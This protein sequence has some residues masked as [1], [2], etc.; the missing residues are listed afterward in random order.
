MTARRAC[1]ACGSRKYSPFA[2]KCFDRELLG[3]LSFASRK[4]PECMRLELVRCLQCDLVYAP[5]LLRY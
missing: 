4:P 1:P 3:D 2:K 5:E